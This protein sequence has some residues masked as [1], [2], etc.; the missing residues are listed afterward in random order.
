MARMDDVSRVRERFARFADEEARGR[1]DV[2]EEWARGVADDEEIAAI[3]ARIPAQH[4]QPPL[5]FAVTRL[6]GADVSDYASWAAFVRAEHAAIVAECTDRTLQTNEPL[7]CAV[8][9]PALSRIDG[10]VAL[11]EL[12]ASGGLCL[13]PDRYSYR[14]SG[15]S[16]EAALDPEDGASPVVLESESRGAGLPPLRVPEVVWRAGID[17]QPRDPRD[18]EDRAW[19]TGLVWPGETGRTERI[20]AAVGIAAAEPPLLVR[21]DVADLALVG[22]V[23]ACAP[24]DATLVVTTPGV[25]PYLP[26]AE[27][28]TL[29]AGIRELDARWITLDQPSLHAAWTTSIDPAAWPGGFALALDGDVLAAADPLGSWLSWRA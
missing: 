1:S 6:V 13:F 4:R 16:G 9:L 23:A 15:P 24:A 21:G 20:D 18:P 5:V 2:Y 28:E 19:L 27:R 22:E 11:L 26:R 17:L 10:P 7:R 3:F 8:L 12:G 14:Y 29:I 25:L